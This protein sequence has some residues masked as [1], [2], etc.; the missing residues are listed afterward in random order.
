ML[1]QN[2]PKQTKISLSEYDKELLKLILNFYDNKKYEEV[3]RI[4]DK[5]NLTTSDQYWIFI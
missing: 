5:I 3:I 4:T 1:L 2:K